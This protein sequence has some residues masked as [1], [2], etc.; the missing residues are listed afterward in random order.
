MHSQLKRTAP[1]FATL[2]FLTA[3]GDAQD[4]AVQPDAAATESAMAPMGGTE[5]P[6]ATV[7][8]KSTGTITAIDKE[9]GTITLDHAAI[10][11]ADW[12]AMAM[13]FAADAATIGDV[14]V[15]DKVSFEAEITGNSGKVTA[16]SKQ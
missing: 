11:E 2:L 9:A 15:G 5:A 13:P 10:P 7:N 12:P 4:A 3:C 6:A 16:I 1:I 8:A 14:K